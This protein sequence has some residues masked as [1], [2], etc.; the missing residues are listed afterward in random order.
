MPISPRVRRGECRIDRNVHALYPR[1]TV[2]KIRGSAESAC[3]QGCL[4]DGVRLPN[5]VRRC[6]IT[7]EPKP[8]RQQSGRDPPVSP[9]GSASHAAQHFCLLSPISC[10]RHG[11]LSSFGLVVR[12]LAKDGHCPFSRPSSRSRS[13]GRE[14]RVIHVTRRCHSRLPPHS[15]RCCR[16]CRRH[17]V[18]VRARPRA[19]SLNRGCLGSD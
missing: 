5:A 16:P 17:D 4:R 10:I 8:Q 3:Q 12:S 18:A 9:F 7:A 11:G 14:I 6:R 13:G 2:G 15:L 19:R 1:V